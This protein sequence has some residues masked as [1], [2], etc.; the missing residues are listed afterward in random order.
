MVEATPE[1][2]AQHAERIQRWRGVLQSDPRRAVRTLTIRGM[3][4]ESVEGD[5][6]LDTP[7]VIARLGEIVKEKESRD[8]WVKLVDAGV[9]SAL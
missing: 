1:Y 6:A 3:S 9:V 5:T 2:M 4:S 8:V 7:Y